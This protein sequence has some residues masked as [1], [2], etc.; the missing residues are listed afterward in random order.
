MESQNAEQQA[1][2]SRNPAEFREQ[3]PKIPGLIREAVTQNNREMFK[4]ADDIGAI[5]VAG[6]FT[7]PDGKY[8]S[9]IDLHG[10]WTELMAHVV[11]QQNSSTKDRLPR[12]VLALRQSKFW[13]FNGQTLLPFGRL[14]GLYEAW[15][16]GVAKICKLLG[17]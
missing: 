16:T 9:P 13:A 5:L 7:T 6:K 15:A 3:Y 8:E 10:L 11:A 14:T 17:L 1:F 12:L 2:L 4:I